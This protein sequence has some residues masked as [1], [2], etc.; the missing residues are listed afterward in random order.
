[1]KKIFLILFC[2][3][4]LH[5]ASCPEYNYPSIPGLDQDMDNVCHNISYP[6]INN[7]TASTL[8]IST[9]TITNLKGTQTN[10]SASSGNVGEWIETDNTVIPS[11]TTGVYKDLLNI[12]LT[13]GDWDVSI[14]AVVNGIT[15]ASLIVIGIG[16]ASGNNTTGFISG[17]NTAQLNV[18]SMSTASLAVPSFRVSIGSGATYYLKGEVTFVSGSPTFDARISARRIR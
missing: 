18:A 14:C 10:N 4:I 3:S 15:G 6:T 8:T 1:M 5:A 2:S 11:G 16:T 17:N 12:T 7:G 13:P 9:A